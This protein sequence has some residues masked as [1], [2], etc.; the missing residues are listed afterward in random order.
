M[1][2]QEGRVL[3]ASVNV[4]GVHVHA[5]RCINHDFL[6]KTPHCRERTSPGTLDASLSLVWPPLLGGGGDRLLSLS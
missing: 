3:L 1:L 6:L 4:S 5:Q 2:E